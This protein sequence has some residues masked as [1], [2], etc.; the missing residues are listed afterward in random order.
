M[1]EAFGVQTQS[2][3]SGIIEP[4]RRSMLPDG[5]KEPLERTR[6]PIERL[7]K[8]PLRHHRAHRARGSRPCSK[9]EAIGLRCFDT[10]KTR[11][12]S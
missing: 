9:T 5:A 6:R 12:C 7:A 3:Y 1:P 2:R 4:G 11:D 10:V 8:T